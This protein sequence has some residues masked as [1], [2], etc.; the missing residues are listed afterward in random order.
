MI[1]CLEGYIR[2]NGSKVIAQTSLHISIFT[3]NQKKWINFVIT[4]VV[5]ITISNYEY[6][7]SGIYHPVFGLRH[8]V[9][10]YY[11]NSYRL[12]FCRR[13]VFLTCSSNSDLL[14][15][16]IQET[17]DS[18]NLDNLKKTH[19]FLLSRIIEYNAVQDDVILKKKFKYFWPELLL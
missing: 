10:I 19:L 12:F 1:C 13:Y 11:I 9:L 16:T 7:F 6:C 18:S 2:F 3:R 17:L 14:C 5:T 8:F 4:N 15:V